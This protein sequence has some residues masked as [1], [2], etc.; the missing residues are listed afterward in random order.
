MLSLTPWRGPGPGR[1]DLPLPPA[2]MPLLRQGRLRKRWRYL[3]VYG[4]ELMIC[5]ARAEVGPLRRAFWVLWDRTEGRRYA[6]TGLLGS[7]AAFDGSEARIRA[8]GTRAQLRLGDAAAVEVVCPSGERG[9]AWTRKRAGIP[10]SGTVEAAGRR[11]KVEARGVDDESAGYHERRIHW[12]WSA[13]VGRSADGRSLAWNLVSGIND[14]PRD[15]ERAIWLEGVPNEPPPVSFAGLDAVGFADGARLRFA[16][17][18]E[19]ARDDNLLLIRSRYRHRFGSFSGRLGGIELERG[20][21]VM[22]EHEVRW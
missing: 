14:P 13:G 22:E 11:W 18:C 16:A 12:R 3:G 6:R 10:V 5:M 20:L 17:E 2:P 15:S 4:E 8:R 9:Y 7:G 19:W 1:P 21:G